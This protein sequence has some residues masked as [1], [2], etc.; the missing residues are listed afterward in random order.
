MNRT[1]CRILIIGYEINDLI[2]AIDLRNANH[3]ILMFERT[4]EFLDV[5]GGIQVPPNATKCLQHLDVLEAVKANA[6]QPQTIILRSYRDG[7]VLSRLTLVPDIELKCNSPFLNV[8]R[9]DLRN[10][11]LER[12]KSLGVEIKL[13]SQVASIDL[14][15]PSIELSSGKV[16]TADVIFGG[17]GDS[18]DQ[19]FSIVLDAEA[20][21]QQE[22]LKSFV[23][24]PTTNVWFGP[25]AHVVA[26]MV[27]RDGFFHMILSRPEQ[28]T[29]PIQSR[30]QQTETDE[31]REFFKVWDPR[32]QGAAQAF[33]DAAVLSA[34]FTK[35]HHK[36]QIPDVLAIYERLRKPRAIALKERSRT[37]RDI[38]GMPDGPLQ[39]ERDR[40]LLQHAPFEGYPNPWADPVAQNWMFGYD[41]YKEGKDAW[42][43]YVKSE[44]P[45]TT[46]M[47]K[48]ANQPGFL[49]DP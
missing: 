22:D 49:R 2:I 31:L 1:P 40:Q 19:V 47:W 32:A 6:I 13:G 33:E 38:N 45:S 41:A 44:W 28:N 36:S 21:R 23:D 4:T 30:P 15:A 18:G 11:L 14:T 34:L 10:V 35:I 48:V 46:G 8:H 20:V 3:E 26:Y 37:M 39:Q 9:N 7:E 5:G 16:Y 42:N 29:Q 24:P 12:A 25:D 17:D 43:I 27:R